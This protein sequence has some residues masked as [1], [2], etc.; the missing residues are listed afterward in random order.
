MS[1]ALAQYFASP[2]D[3]IKVQIQMEGKRRLMGEPP[4]YNCIV[5]NVKSQF[6]HFF[7]LFHSFV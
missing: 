6:P 2:A 5:C 1:G 4:R 7:F 3:L